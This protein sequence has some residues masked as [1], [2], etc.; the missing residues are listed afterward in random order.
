MNS[1]NTI[2][3]NI[4]RL[5]NLGPVDISS[6]L[7]TYLPF[8][9]ELEGY[10][11]NSTIY[12]ST[13]T[14]SGGSNDVYTK[15]T[16]SPMIVTSNQKLGRG[17]I[18]FN[19]TN[20]DYLSPYFM[21]NT[22]FQTA[23]NST[24]FS[25]SF[26]F[27]ANNTNGTIFSYSTETVSPDFTTYTTGHNPIY[28]YINNNNLIAAVINGDPNTPTSSGLV[29]VFNSVNDNVW[30]HFVWTNS[31]N[32]WKFYINGNLVNT[33]TSPAPTNAFRN[34][35][36]IGANISTSGENYGFFNG[37]LDD[38]RFYNIVLNQRQVTALY[39]Y[40]YTF[41]I[42][43]NNTNNYT[44]NLYSWYSFDADTIDSST[45]N[46]KIYNISRGLYDATIVKD[47]NTNSMYPTLTP[48]A[49]IGNCVLR[50]DVL[51][52][53]SM[54]FNY[55]LLESFPSTLTNANALSFSFWFFSSSSLTWARIFDFGN[56]VASDNIIAYINSNNLGLAVYGG[57][58]T[59]NPVSQ[60]DNIFSSVN[61][62]IWRHVVWT[63][64]SSGTWK[65]YING[66]LQSTKTSTRYPS[67]VSRSLNYLGKSNWSA[68]PNFK[69]GI[70]DFRIYKQELTQANV[71]TLYNYR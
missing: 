31:S 67:N 29:T 69:G 2:G 28:L 70:D 52:N 20:N 60:F 33:Y 27:R 58:S 55:V 42:F 18:S 6:N 10:I 24:Q 53:N 39:N 23:L 14:P 8:D 21:Y 43:I 63:L 65:I 46:Y 56:G 37:G 40:N 11:I 19:S 50:L 22:D 49:K 17:H 51:V 68:D 13:I 30:R 48:F 9:T 54:I 66:V 12:Q 34:I 71:T 61:D 45:G 3:S 44:T 59:T 38:F 16:R 62:G 15:S 7:V 47:S 1:F 5:T 4:N 57:N 25:F 26:W 64:N 35:G 32:V 41:S 36:Y